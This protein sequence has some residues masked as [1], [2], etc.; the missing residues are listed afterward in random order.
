MAIVTKALGPDFL[1]LPAQINECMETIRLQSQTMQEES[2]ARKRHTQIMDQA[3]KDLSSL[4]ARPVPAPPS[5][6]PWIITAVLIVF[7]AV[8]AIVWHSSIRSALA[9]IPMVTI[10]SAEKRAAA[11]E[12]LAKLGA[13]I[14]QKQKDLS[15]MEAELSRKR[16]ETMDVTQSLNTTL[17]ARTQ[18]QLEL[19]S[20]ETLKQ[21]HRGSLIP[22]SNGHLYAEVT[23][24]PTP[25]LYNGKWYVEVKEASATT[26]TMK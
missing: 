2:Q 6:L 9:A 18:A 12:E 11:R 22:G 1:N 8:G 25:F 14:E 10:E 26:P 3:A 17:Q 20:M 15:S 7:L 19:G 5:K 4:R 23:E 21:R 16:S 13:Q 24:N